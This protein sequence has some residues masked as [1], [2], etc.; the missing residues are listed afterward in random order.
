MF[1]FCQSCLVVQ[2]WNCRYVIY[3]TPLICFQ[4]HLLI[5]IMFYFSQVP[6]LFNLYVGELQNA[7]IKMETSSGLIGVLLE[8]CAIISPLF[9]EHK[10]NTFLWTSLSLNLLLE[11][12]LSIKSCSWNYNIWM[13]QKFVELNIVW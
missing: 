8:Y 10:V 3:W 11:E 7:T 12:F 9:E 2:K 6:S 1:S 5:M 4:S 13:E